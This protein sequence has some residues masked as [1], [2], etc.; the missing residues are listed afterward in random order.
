MQYNRKSASEVNCEH[1]PNRYWRQE[2]RYN[3]AIQLKELQRT[4][5]INRHDYWLKADY[6]HRCQVSD[7]LAI[8]PKIKYSI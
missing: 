2:T 3:S 6:L 5:D 1:L 7:R 8:S 4:V